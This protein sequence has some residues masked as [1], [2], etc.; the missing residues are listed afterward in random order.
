MPLTSI[1][2]TCAKKII[3]RKVIDS[4]LNAVVTIACYWFIIKAAGREGE[5]LRTYQLKADFENTGVTR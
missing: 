1:R 3:P 2:L 5:K 4:S